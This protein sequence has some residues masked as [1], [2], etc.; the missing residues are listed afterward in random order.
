MNF[1]TFMQTVSVITNV[2]MS[3]DVNCLYRNEILYIY[4]CVTETQI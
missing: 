4:N 3:A 1:V 2:Q